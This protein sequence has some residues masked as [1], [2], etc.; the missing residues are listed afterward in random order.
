MEFKYT[1]NLGEEKY[2]CFENDN[3]I[4]KVKLEKIE[5][6]NKDE[7]LYGFKLVNS[8]K[9]GYIDGVYSYKPYFSKYK[10]SYYTSMAKVSDIFD[11]LEEIKDCMLENIS[12]FYKNEIKKIELSNLKVTDKKHSIKVNTDYILGDKIYYYD[13]WLNKLKEG[14]IE[15]ITLLKEEG[16][17]SILYDVNI[18][19]R[20][21][22]EIKTKIPKINLY[23]SPEEFYNKKARE[24]FDSYKVL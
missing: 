9:Y 3:E 15:G 17:E 14:S 21:D 2:I 22:F 24:M 8:T 18:K 1:Y 7:E 4:V 19:T 11:S 12:K 20:G 16:R 13:L 5:I 23:K 10:G 6:N